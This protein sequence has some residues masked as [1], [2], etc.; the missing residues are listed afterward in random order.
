MQEEADRLSH[1]KVAQLRPQREEMIILNPERG[2]GLSEPQ[3]RAR[4]EG[5]DFAIGQIIALRDAD[6]IGARMQRRPQGRI[7][8]ALVISAVMRSRQIQHRERARAER[9][10]FGKWFLLDAVTDA[11]AGTD[12]NRA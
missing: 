4:H 1:A 3:Q 2:I 11:P 9:L 8:K 6:Q 10:D 5:V 7:G 12:P